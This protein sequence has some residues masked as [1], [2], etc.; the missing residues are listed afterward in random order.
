MSGIK[1]AELPGLGKK[2]Q[3]ELESGESVV[4]VI[5]DEGHRELFYF[6]ADESEPAC[7]FT[8][9]DQEARQIGSIIGGAFYQPRM[10]EKLE[11]AIAELRIEWL[12]V[13]PD[14]QVAGKSIGDLGLRKNLGITVIAII[15]E[16]K[17]G[18]KKTTAINPGPS[19][20]FTPG[21]IMVVAGKTGSIEQFQ[22]MVTGKGE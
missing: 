17:K 16:D 22:V 3:V 8:M 6:P 7:S 20:V 15:E 5:Y 4:V 9:T 10:L 19:F 21:Q 12:K 18:K 2:Y 11:M 1:E 13:A 14:A